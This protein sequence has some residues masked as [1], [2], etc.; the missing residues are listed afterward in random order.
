M[1]RGASK[2]HLFATP[3]RVNNPDVSFNLLWEDG[4]HLHFHP[5]LYQVIEL[6]TLKSAFTEKTVLVA[7]RRCGSQES[8]VFDWRKID[9][10]VLRERSEFIKIGHFSLLYWRGNS[11]PT[12]GIPPKS[13]HAAQVNDPHAP[14]NTN[15]RAMSSHLTMTKWA[16]QVNW[17]C[18]HPLIHV[19]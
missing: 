3:L 13:T 16:K 9:K 18:L 5:G 4:W 14:L 10:P 19:A 17:S 15:C 7:L 11:E 2:A 12:Q 6:S 1:R 8:L